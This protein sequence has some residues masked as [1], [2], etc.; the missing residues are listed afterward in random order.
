MSEGEAWHLAG[1]DGML[2]RITLGIVDEHTER[3]EDDVHQ[4]AMGEALQNCAQLSECVLKASKE[5]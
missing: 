4:Q 2:F 5:G 1:A 3:V